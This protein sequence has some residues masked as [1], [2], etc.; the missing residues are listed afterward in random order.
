MG[1]DGVTRKEPLLF[2]VHRIPYP[3]NKGD[4]IRSFNMLRWL[5]KRYDVYLGCFVDDASE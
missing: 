2:L 3:P 4:K 1:T 5:S